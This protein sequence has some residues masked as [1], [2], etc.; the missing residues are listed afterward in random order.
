MPEHFVCADPASPNELADRI[1]HTA[2]R[3][4][5]LAEQFGAG[6]R[7]DDGGRLLDEMDACLDVLN[8]A[9]A[10]ESPPTPQ[11]DDAA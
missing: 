10:E 9:W 1:R 4:A 11:P 2:A 8:V 6:P 3:L 5:R 7:G